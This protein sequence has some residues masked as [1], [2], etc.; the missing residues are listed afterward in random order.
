[1]LRESLSKERTR[2]VAAA[3]SFLLYCSRQDL[4]T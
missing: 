3:N 1:M 2:S 4:T